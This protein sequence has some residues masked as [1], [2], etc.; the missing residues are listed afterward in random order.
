MQV[1]T[2]PD[3]DGAQVK[4]YFNMTQLVGGLGWRNPGGIISYKD[5]KL[6]L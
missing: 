5:T 3:I 2:F 1:M 6:L 4:S